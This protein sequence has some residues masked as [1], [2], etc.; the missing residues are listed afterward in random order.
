MWDDEEQQLVYPWKLIR[1]SEQQREARLHKE[2]CLHIKKQQFQTCLLRRHQV[3]TCEKGKQKQHVCSEMVQDDAVEM[4]RKQK[5]MELLHG[6]DMRSLNI[7]A[8]TDDK[9][10]LL[11]SLPP[12]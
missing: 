12:K 9:S 5:K 3:T 6:L 8:C 2:E 11:L 10:Y 7:F 1:G 4:E